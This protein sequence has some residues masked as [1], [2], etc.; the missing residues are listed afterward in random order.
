MNQEEWNKLNEMHHRLKSGGIVSFSSEFLERYSELLA[1]SLRG[2]GNE[3][4][5]RSGTT[6]T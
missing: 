1:K 5:D 3:L 4:Y 6:H 2:K